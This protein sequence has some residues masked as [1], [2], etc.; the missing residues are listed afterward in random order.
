MPTPRS[1]PARPAPR[2][3]HRRALGD[4]VRDPA[5]AQRPARQAPDLP[6]GGERL[7]ALVDATRELEPR[8]QRPIGWGGRRLDE[9]LTD[10]ERLFDETGAYL[11]LDG[12]LELKSS[13]PIGY[14]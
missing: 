13:D 8:E 2:A 9:M 5:G 10:S 1:M 12:E 3:G 7:M 14:E 4:H 6:P 11:G